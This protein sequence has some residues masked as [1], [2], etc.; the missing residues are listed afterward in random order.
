MAVLNANLRGQLRGTYRIPYDELCKHEVVVQ[1]PKGK[2]ALDI[3]KGLIDHG[4][5]PPTHLLVVVKGDAHRANRDRVQR[6]PRRLRRRDARARRER[7]A[8]GSPERGT[9]PPPRRGPRRPPAEGQVVAVAN[10]APQRTPLYDEHKALGARL[11]DFAG[12]E[13]PVQYE[14]IKAEHNAVRNHAGLFDVSHMGEAV[15]RGPD[16]EEAVQRLVTRDVSRLDEGQAG[17]SAVCYEDGGTVDD[18][19][20]Y[21]RSDDFLIVVNASN[22]EKDL[23]HFRNNT[24]DLDV[25]VADESDDWALLALQGPEAADILQDLTDTDLSPPRLSGS[26]KERLPAPGPSS[27][28]PDTPGK[29]ASS[30]TCP[31][32]TPHASGA[33]SSRPAR[34]R[35]GWERATLKAGGRDVPLRQRARSRDDAA[36]GRHRLRRPPGQG[37]GVHRPGGSEKEKEEGLRKKLVGFEVEGRHRTSRLPRESGGR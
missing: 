8:R 15:F 23:D 35:P 24:D 5:H 16:A 4:F 18:V 19:I 32:T 27:P 25:E 6:D 14:G 21:R 26:W 1:P 28:A 12:W 7:G 17:Y 36:G 31:P 22:R 9:H 37:A 34:P 10:E 13:M 29:T 33:R 30:S 3:A 2:K 11:V 20:V